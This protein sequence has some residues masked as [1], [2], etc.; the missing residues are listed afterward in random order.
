MLIMLRL[1][2]FYF[3]TVEELREM[4]LRV[5][6]RGRMHAHSHIYLNAEYKDVSR[7]SYE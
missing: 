3:F 6:T 1:K 4:R 7:S 2:T 5:Y